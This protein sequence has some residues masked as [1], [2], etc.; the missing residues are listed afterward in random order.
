MPNREEMK[1]H[2]EV[3]NYLE[4]VRD[5]IDRLYFSAI[6]GEYHGSLKHRQ[7]DIDSTIA[8]N[9]LECYQR[10]LEKNQCNDK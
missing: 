10:D 3:E 8:L 6:D 5:A 7:A 2:T 4:V 1:K 9:Y